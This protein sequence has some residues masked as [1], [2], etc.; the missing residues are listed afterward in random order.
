M[1]KDSAD[2]ELGNVIRLSLYLAKAMEK[3]GT[4]FWRVLEIM[5]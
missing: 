3:W 5:F 4:S 1:E 2:I